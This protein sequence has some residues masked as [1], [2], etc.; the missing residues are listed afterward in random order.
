MRSRGKF[1]K[2]GGTWN[3]IRSHKQYSPVLLF[4][5]CLL[6][7]LL[8]LFLQLSVGIEDG[9]LQA[10]NQDFE[11]QFTH[12]IWQITRF[13]KVDYDQ[14]SF[15]YLMRDDS[16]TLLYCYLFQAKLSSDVST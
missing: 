2:G 3:K 5:I 6:L 10:Y 16:D 4:I 1:E 15:L 8:L 13:S 9:V 11:L 14:L 12:K 7:L